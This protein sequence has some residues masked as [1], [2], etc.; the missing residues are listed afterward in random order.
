MGLIIGT[1]IMIGG[2][3]SGGSSAGNDVYLVTEDN[4]YIVTESYDYIII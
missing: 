1:G 2:R 3:G 4:L